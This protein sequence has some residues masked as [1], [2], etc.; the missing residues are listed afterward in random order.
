MLRDNISLI[1]SSEYFS[2]IQM[3]W[4]IFPVQIFVQRLKNPFLDNYK[5][6]VCVCL[7]NLLTFVA[8]KF[9]LNILESQKKKNKKICRDRNKIDCQCRCFDSGRNFGEENMGLL[10]RGRKSCRAKSYVGMCVKEGQHIQTV[11]APFVVQ[12]LAI[13]I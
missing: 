6:R 3:S 10:K 13:V 5:L 7:V 9:S 12:V 8:R 11:L 1:F 4:K 2:Q